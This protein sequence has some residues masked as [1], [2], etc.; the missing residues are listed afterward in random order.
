MDTGR[1]LI[2]WKLNHRSFPLLARVARRVLAI[3]AT[4]AS[5]ERAFSEAGLL[6]SK[7]RTCLRSELVGQMTKLRGWY[8]LMKTNNKATLPNIYLFE[9][10]T[11][12]TTYQDDEEVIEVSD[13]NDEKG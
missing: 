4:S 12:S 11:E 10:D 1:P 5:S 3:P 13:S 6:I 7:R 8:K 2:W 9:E